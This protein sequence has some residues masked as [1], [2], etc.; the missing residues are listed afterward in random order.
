MPKYISEDGFEESRIS[1]STEVTKEFGELELFAISM[2]MRQARKSLGWEL[3][4]GGSIVSS[5]SIRGSA[6]YFGCCDKNFYAVSLE[7]KVIWKTATDVPITTDPAIGGGIV[8]FTAGK[9]LNAIDPDGR[10][11]WRF[12]APSELYSPGYHNGVIYVGGFDGNFY[13][14]HAGDGEKMW[15]F[16]ARG[17]IQSKPT[18]HEERIYFGSRDNHV[19]A[20]SLGGELVWKFAAKNDV[21]LEPAVLGNLICFGSFDHNVYA[22]DYHSARLAWKFCTNEAV[23]TSIVTDGKNF[24]FGSNNGNLYALS[25]DGIELWHFKTA[26]ML[27]RTPTIADGVI[28][29]GSWDKSLYAIKTD[30]TFLWKFPTSEPVT[31]KPTV[32]NQIVYFGSMDCHLYAVN[33]L[34]GGLL[35]SFP[36]SLSYPSSFQDYEKESIATTAQTTWTPVT[37]KEK[38]KKDEADI[39]GYGEFSGHYIDV[40]KSDYLGRR[41]KGYM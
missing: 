20:L 21:Y 6:I 17:S 18:I 37:K 1:F 13:A 33:A 8:F 40:T 3:G 16:V 11:L 32:F 29:F 9:E 24:Y 38:Y 4:L 39:A 35:W 12:V 36:T 2:G 30:G 34:T 7:G 14:I 19:Y 28:Y 22:I 26:G 15:R 5:P 27:W 41:K 23:G 10:L 31:T 25:R